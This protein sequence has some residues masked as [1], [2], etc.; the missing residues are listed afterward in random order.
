M[1]RLHASFNCKET[2]YRV[3]VTEF[4]QMAEYRLYPDG[5][6]D[7]SHRQCSCSTPGR[8][9]LRCTRQI[10]GIGNNTLGRRPTGYAG[11]GC[12]HA[13]CLRVALSPACPGLYRAVVTACVW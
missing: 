7:L 3:V 11:H 10:I 9:D 13:G 2:K 1:G 6:V 12:R 4:G 8:L 5:R